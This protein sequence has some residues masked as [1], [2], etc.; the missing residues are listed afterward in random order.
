MTVL[1]EKQFTDK[2]SRL[3]NSQQS[4]ESLSGWCIF[5]RKVIWHHNIG[6]SVT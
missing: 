3:N 1:N 5:Y 4:I 2:M 6:S